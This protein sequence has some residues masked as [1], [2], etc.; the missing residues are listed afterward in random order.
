M[1]NT[2]LNRPII[3]VQ[4]WKVEPFK[5]E[6]Y[7]VYKFDKISDKKYSKFRLDL[8]CDDD[9]EYFVPKSDLI[10]FMLK[11]IETTFIN[12]NIKITNST[13]TNHKLKLIIE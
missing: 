8:D 13:I 3:E 6:D 9:I 11:G 1:K 5:A 4:G 7:E 12:A 2:E 10:G